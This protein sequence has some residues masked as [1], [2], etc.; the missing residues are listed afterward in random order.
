MTSLLDLKL[1]Q[2]WERFFE[3]LGEPA[4]RARQVMAWVYQRLITRFD[5]M[6]D[7][8]LRL[9]RKLEATA[10]V[11]S[12]RLVQ[13]QRGNGGT[14]KLLRAL[15][16]GESVE[17]VLLPY[18]YG[19][20]VCLSAQV[21]CRQGCRFCASGHAGF[22][23]SLTAGEIM[24]Q[25]LAA[26]RQAAPRRISRLVMMGMGE[27]LDNYDQVVAF[28][29]A[30]HAPEGPGLSFRHMTVSTVGLVPGIR[31]LAEEG[32]P[33]NLAISLHAADDI[34]R[35]SIMPAN[36]LFGV[37]EVVA[38]GREYFA[39]T[40]RR[41]TWE[42]ILLRGV[43]DTPLAGTALV[44]LLDPGAHVNL[45][46][47]NP[48]PGLDYEPPAPDEVRAFA[49]LL[50]SGGLR[51]TVRR[52]LGAAIEGA[53]GQLR[54]RH[55]DQMRRDEDGAVFGGL[56][57]RSGTRDQRGQ[58]LPSPAGAGGAGGG[59]RRDR[60]AAAGGGGVGPGHPDPGGSAGPG[61]GS[62]LRGAGT[63]AGGGRGPGAGA[64]PPRVGGSAPAKP[65]GHDPDRRPGVG[66]RSAR[67]PRR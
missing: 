38:A 19:D 5:E 28:L 43:T 60:R 66:P 59:G 45:I 65:D 33:V 15:P 17:T 51:V 13:C 18:R 2:E 8:P 41:V 48:V 32:I 10:V 24:A 47:Y 29:R 49:R 34:T 64:H 27:P 50:E 57:S 35:R 3:E 23:R 67:R 63:A 56:G 25:F 40:S 58:L 30:A 20:S 44:K 62:H 21:G 14:V 52:Q 16:D 7:L 31:R 61:G 11:D 4:Y 46:P 9:R 36:R 37:A 54:R 1:P 39:R 12:A 55:L 26:A 42:Y 53:C 6:T 22:I